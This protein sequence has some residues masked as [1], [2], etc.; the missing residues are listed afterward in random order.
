MN[1]KQRKLIFK[2]IKRA[3]NITKNEID[4]LTYNL[5]KKC[6]VNGK[7][8][9]V[10]TY[11]FFRDS[12]EYTTEPYIEKSVHIIPAFYTAYR[13]FKKNALHLADSHFDISIKKPTNF[14]HKKY[15]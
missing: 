10:K 15:I 9:V 6:T 12:T 13:L 7:I 1:K 11:H 2:G 4:L 8:A 5:I 14:Y 3:T